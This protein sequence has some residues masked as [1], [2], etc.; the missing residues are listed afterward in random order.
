MHCEVDVVNQPMVRRAVTNCAVVRRSLAALTRR[1]LFP[2]RLTC[3]IDGGSNRGSRANADLSKTSAFS[4][5]LAEK[6]AAQTLIKKVVRLVSDSARRAHRT[7]PALAAPKVFPSL[8]AKGLTCSNTPDGGRSCQP[9][10]NLPSHASKVNAELL[11]I[12]LSARTTFSER[13]TESQQG[14]AL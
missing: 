8:I 12:L 14:R 1:G 9:P 13:Q 5:I 10:P 6:P 3:Q 7:G 4:L 2:L 11:R